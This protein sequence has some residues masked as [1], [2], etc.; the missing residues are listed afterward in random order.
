MFQESFFFPHG[1]DGKD[2]VYVSFE[3][4]WDIRVYGDAGEEIF[5]VVTY[6]KATDLPPDCL[7]V[8]RCCSELQLNRSSE[9]RQG[10][11]ALMSFSRSYI[12]ERTFDFA[13]HFHAHRKM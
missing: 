8:L 13:H 7:A 2:V 6:Y 9:D 5:N 12:D 10:P 3:K 11:P 1:S 4:D